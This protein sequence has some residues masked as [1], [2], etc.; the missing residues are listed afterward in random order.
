[1]D[2]GQGGVILKLREVRDVERKPYIHSYPH[3]GV[4]NMKTDKTPLYLRTLCVGSFVALS[5]S[6]ILPIIAKI[7]GDPVDVTLTFPYLFAGLIG[8]NA[9]EVSS[10]L[11]KRVISIEKQATLKNNDAS[12]NIKQ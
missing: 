3:K 11:Y 10:R 5:L 12:C 6:V 8:V 1:M 4:D 2:F 9:Y 7:E